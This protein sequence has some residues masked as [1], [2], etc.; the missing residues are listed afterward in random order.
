VKPTEGQQPVKPTWPRTVPL[1]YPIQFGSETIT[2]LEF[3]RGKAGDMKGISLKDEVPANDLML[4]A[5]RLCG[6]APKVIELVDIEDIGEVTDIALDFYVSF[7]AA[8]KKR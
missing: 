4:I 5:S 2:Q 1:K 7:L 6:R 8:G 3:R